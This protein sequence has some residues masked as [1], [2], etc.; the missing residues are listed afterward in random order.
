MSS[1]DLQIA[2]LLTKGSFSSA[3]WRNLISLARIEEPTPVP[4]AAAMKTRVS[5]RGSSMEALS[6][7]LEHSVIVFKK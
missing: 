3:T 6:C 7:H 2:D 1:T 5:S 4:K